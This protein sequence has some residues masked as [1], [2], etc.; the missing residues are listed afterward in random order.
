MNASVPTTEDSI[1]PPAMR[2]VPGGD[3]THYEMGYAYGRFVES[4]RAGSPLSLTVL[5]ARIGVHRTTLGRLLA[6]D[7]VVRPTDDANASAD[8][9]P[10]D[11]TN[12]IH[13]HLLVLAIQHP[14]WTPRALLAELRRQIPQ[15][16]EDF[17]TPPGV[18]KL[19]R[20]WLPYERATRRPPLNA[21]NRMQRLRFLSQIDITRLDDVVWSDE[22]AIAIEGNNY[23]WLTGDEMK[24][25]A[26]RVGVSQKFMFW[27]AFSFRFG[28]LPCRIW[29]VGTAVT[30]DHYRRDVLDTVV[31]PWFDALPQADRDAVLWQ[32]DNARV[33]TDAQVSAWIAHRRLTTI[34]WPPY[35][36]DLTAAEFPWAVMK[37]LV[38]SLSPSGGLARPGGATAAVF[39]PRVISSVW[40][41]ATRPE[42]LE[43][44]RRKVV[45]NWESCIR[46]SGDNR[47]KT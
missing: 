42:R 28:V 40:L 20:K 3:M 36:P 19:V 9:K 8:L 2:H 29:P 45:D 5:A 25:D 32:Q 26:V 27:G 4:Q 44:Y 14:S 31:G 41:L 7:F 21:D 17:I 30:A 37:S 1:L 34:V 43:C 38:N 12:P 24:Y 47:H 10:D 13:M 6:K 35:S 22:A 33:H 18:L 23:R 11:P 39:I 16:P 46:S 15:L